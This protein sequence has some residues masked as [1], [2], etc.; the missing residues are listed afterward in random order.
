MKEIVRVTASLVDAIFRT[1]GVVTNFVA[2][3]IFIYAC[4]WAKAGVIENLEII[5]PLPALN[6]QS[7]MTAVHDPILMVRLL[8]A[9][10]AWCF[11]VLAVGTAWMSLLGLR[12]TFHAS[13]ALIHRLKVI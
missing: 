8:A 9:T 3:G 13:L 12:W 5:G 1:G 11:G 10:K 4:L 6:T 2:L 7:L